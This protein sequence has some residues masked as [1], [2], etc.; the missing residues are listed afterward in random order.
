[1]VSFECLCLG[2]VIMIIATL[3]IVGINYLV[4]AIV[5]KIRKPDKT[6]LEEYH[7]RLWR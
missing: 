5:D 6:N 2:V 7:F 3:T 4:W 1:M